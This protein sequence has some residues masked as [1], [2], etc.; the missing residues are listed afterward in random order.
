MERNSE[1]AIQ[2]QNSDGRETADTFHAGT[3]AEDGFGGV[4]AVF[5]RYGTSFQKV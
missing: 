1:Q 5:G 2:E 4:Q 3:V